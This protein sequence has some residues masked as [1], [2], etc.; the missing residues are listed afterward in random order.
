MGKG[1]PGAKRGYLSRA[2]MAQIIKEAHAECAKEVP[3][4]SHKTPA[5]R[6]R[7]S[8]DKDEYQN[9]IRRKIQNKVYERLKALGVN[10]APPT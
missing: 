4:R 6:T 1:E 3:V 2:T 7:L 10:V 9:C 8:K 5:G